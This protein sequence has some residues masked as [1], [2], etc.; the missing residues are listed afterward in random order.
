MRGFNGEEELKEIL[1]KLDEW[2]EK[3]NESKERYLAVAGVE[4]GW[5]VNNDEF[6]NEKHFSMYIDEEE[7]AEMKEGSKSY[8][9]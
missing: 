2:N 8:E 6:D 9:D 3:Y 7:M 4:G 1:V 5:N